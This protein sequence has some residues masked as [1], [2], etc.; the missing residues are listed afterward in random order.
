MDMMKVLF[1]QR[2][3]QLTR[4][5]ECDVNG[6]I[7]VSGPGGGLPVTIA[8]GADVAQGATTDAEAAAGNGSVIALLKRL[9]TLLGFGAVVGGGAE[10]TALRVTV[11]NDSTGVLDV[12]DRIGRLLG[13]ITNYDVLANGTLGTLNATLS[14]AGAGLST[15]GLGISGT[16]VGTIVAEVETGDGIWD[17]IPLVDNTM[18]SAALST[19]VN[20]NFLLGVA[21]ALT[22][23]IRM[24]LYT[25][26][27]ATV[28]LEG[29]SAPAGVFLSRS[30]PTGVNDIGTVGVLNGGDVTQGAT[31]D[32]AIVTDAV[33]TI[34]GKLRGLVKWAFERMPAALGQG[35][36][37]QSLPVVVASN[38]SGVPVTGTFWQATQPVHGGLADDTVASGNPVA[39]GA[40][41]DET[42]PAAVTEGRLGW[43]RMTLY[44]L[45]RISDSREAGAA[46]L[47]RTVTALWGK[48]PPLATDANWSTNPGQRS[49]ARFFTD[50]TIRG[51]TALLDDPVITFRP[52]VRNGVYVGAAESVS[53]TRSR[54]K[55]LNTIKLQKTVDN[56]ANY[57]DYSASVIDNSAATQADIDALDTAANGDWFVIGG[58]VP[59]IGAAL[60]M[61]AANVNGNASVLTVE[62]WTGAAWAAVANLVDGTIAV[63]GKTLSGDGQISWDL[64]TGWAA[65][66]INSIT[67]Y[68]V[69]CSVSAAVSAAVDIEECDLLMPIKAAIDVQVDGDDV[70]LTLMSQDVTVTGTVAYSGSLYL[71]WR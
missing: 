9:R 16:W 12:T 17:P 69:R 56:G 53:Y 47:H 19:T 50:L 44:R 43:L 6:N 21:G 24:S 42:G 40:L 20:G 70:L 39:V 28:Y 62:Y 59:F 51:C 41:A 27:T 30:I 2:D 7:Y 65:S 48:Q 15:I 61:D 23:R 46:A 33:G 35:T 32:A 8:D 13:K 63:A 5:P 55:D 10:A 38:Q 66:T 18:G 11:A 26:G 4:I 60:D 14:I 71:S 67:A 1:R 45:L 34:S 68:W 58:P 49:R 37:A 29:T 57:T 25:S 54:L 22:V 64:P 31:A 36:M 52:Y 3:T